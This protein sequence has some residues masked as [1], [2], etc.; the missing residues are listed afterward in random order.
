MIDSLGTSIKLYTGR[1]HPEVQLLTL[2]N[3]IFSRKGTPF[4]NLL[5]INVAHVKNLVVL[6][7]P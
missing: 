7:L 6:C 2:L 5:L 1:L 3:A 4:V